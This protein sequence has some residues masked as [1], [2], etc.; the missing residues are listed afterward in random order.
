[1]VML[2]LQEGEG[3]PGEDL[4]EPRPQNRIKA[5][6]EALWDAKL[7]LI[8]KLAQVRGY[9]RERQIKLR[10]GEYMADTNV[11]NLMRYA[12]STGRAM[13]GLRE[14]VDLLNE[15]GVK[16]HEVWNDHVKGM[17]TGD[18][19]T[20]ERPPATQPPPA[21]PTGVKRKRD[22]PTQEEEE[23]PVKR[24]RVH[25]ED[26]MPGPPTLQRMEE[27]SPPVELESEEELP[28]PPPLK[29][30]PIKEGRLHVNKPVTPVV[31]EEYDDDE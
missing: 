8:L 16:P 22:H 21:P 11:I 4:P 23:A 14:F 5:R 25:Y 30:N 6:A 31:W 7:N 15:A 13:A 20:R 28:P 29:Y 3:V 19:L 12:L 17:M 10:S 18:R 26:D 2:P 1:M 9:N 27:P 24:K